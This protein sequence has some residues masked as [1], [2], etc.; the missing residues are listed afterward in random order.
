MQSCPPC[1][2]REKARCGEDSFSILNQRLHT[3][4]A[5]NFAFILSKTEQINPVELV[6]S[7]RVFEEA[8]EEDRMTRAIKRASRKSIITTTVATASIFAILMN[9]S[10]VVVFMNMLSMLGELNWRF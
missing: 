3:K 4:A 2:R 8:F 9:F 7:M 10:I 6:E 5:R 1:Y